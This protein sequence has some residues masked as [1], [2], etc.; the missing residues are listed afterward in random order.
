MSIL[1]SHISALEALRSPLLSKTSLTTVENTLAAPDSKPA[2]Y[3][4]EQAAAILET[5][6]NRPQDKIEVLVSDRAARMRTH[7][8]SAHIHSGILP[9]R[10]VIRLTQDVYCAGPALIAAQLA[11]EFEDLETIMLLC[12]LLGTYGICK[13]A[14][15]G[16]TQRF[17]PPET[18]ASLSEK[19]LWL[20]GMRGVERARTLLRHACSGAASPQEAKTS[21]R[22]GLRPGLGGYGIVPTSMNES[23][24]TSDFGEVFPNHVRK[25]DILFL[26]RDGDATMIPFRG[27]AL[28]YKGRDYHSTPEQ[29]A[30]D[31]RRRNELLAIGIKDYEIDKLCY[32]NS[33]YMDNLAEQIRR[34]LG[35]PGQRLCYDESARRRKLRRSLKAKLDA[36]DGVHWSSRAP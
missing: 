34:D 4:L 26:A 20:R 27:V 24:I 33:I 21:L 12:E 16:M 29:M 31:A 10:S 3:E 13:S 22:F 9:P 17:E 6:G 11:A 7:E 28:E 8:V 5:T 23:L 1:L 32:D 14:P 15:A 35:R 36:I 25:P 30:E 18:K 19:L 2:A